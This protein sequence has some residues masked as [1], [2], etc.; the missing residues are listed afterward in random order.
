MG[1]LPFMQRSSVCAALDPSQKAEISREKVILWTQSARDQQEILFP[2]EDNII[3]T[4]WT[5]MTEHLSPENES[6]ALEQK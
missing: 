6:L 4:L 1:K 2:L 5:I 3:H